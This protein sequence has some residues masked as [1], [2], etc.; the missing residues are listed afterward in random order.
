MNLQLQNQLEK[1]PRIFVKNCYVKFQEK[2]S[3]F[4]FLSFSI[5]KSR[6]VSILSFKALINLQDFDLYEVGK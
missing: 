1:V 3:K 6:S 2:Y 5:R 4:V